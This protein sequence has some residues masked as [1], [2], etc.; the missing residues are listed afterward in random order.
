MTKEC[1]LAGIKFPMPLSEP[2]V[3]PQ[4]YW[5]ADLGSKSTPYQTRW[6]DDPVDLYYLKAGLIH[7]TKRA[8]AQQQKAVLA[9]IKQAIKQA[10][11]K[12]G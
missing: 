10:K 9:A 8:A 3:K 5:V 12:T 4:T 1:T 7:T 11:E 6:R 2:L